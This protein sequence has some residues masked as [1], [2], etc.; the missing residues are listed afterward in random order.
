MSS[1]KT[2]VLN[3]PGFDHKRWKLLY[4]R[5]MMKVWSRIEVNRIWPSQKK[6]SIPTLVTQ[7]QS[8]EISAYQGINYYSPISILS[9]SNDSNLETNTHTALPG[10][11]RYI[12][13]GQDAR[14][15]RVSWFS[16]VLHQ[17]GNRCM[18]KI[19]N[20]YSKFSLSEVHL[21]RAR[22]P[23]HKSFIINICTS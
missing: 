4:I 10:V 1:A 18:I 3:R 7:L 16:F 5:W 22:C 17:I 14:T 21:V 12:S 23:H 19:P 2:Q 11:M 8:R 15:T 9:Y 6:L 20:I 13:S